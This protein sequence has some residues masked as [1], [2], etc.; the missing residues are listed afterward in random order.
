ME[1][2]TKHEPAVTQAPYEEKME[3]DASSKNPQRLFAGSV[4]FI[5][6]R[7]RE[8]PCSVPGEYL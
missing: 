4:F 1:V 8:I 7:G 2:I 5:P 3:F 6:V